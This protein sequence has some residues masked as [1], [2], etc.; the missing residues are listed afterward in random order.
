M[1]IGER[2]LKVKRRISRRKN[3][4]GRVKTAWMVRSHTFNNPSRG[5]NTSS[6]TV[7]TQC[8][9]SSCLNTLEWNCWSRLLIHCKDQMIDQTQVNQISYLRS[10]D[11]NN[12]KNTNKSG[13]RGLKHQWQ[14][15]Q[16]L[17]FWTGSPVPQK[18]MQTPNDFSVGFGGEILILKTSLFYTFIHMTSLRSQILRIHRFW[19]YLHKREYPFKNNPRIN[20]IYLEKFC[21]KSCGPSYNIER[22]LTGVSFLLFYTCRHPS[23]PCCFISSL[24]R[25]LYVSM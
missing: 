21:F 13:R 12:F 4:E 25:Q 8:F 1:A 6:L 23:K 19:I 15:P 3:T 24:H 17:S 5:H 14:L 18:Q 9:N 11:T 2:I 10:S 16:A 20:T 22:N 7:I